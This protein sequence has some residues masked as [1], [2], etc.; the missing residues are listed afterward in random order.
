MDKSMKLKYSPLYLAISVALSGCLNSSDSTVSTGVFVDNLVSGMAYETTTQS[1]FTNTKGEFKYAEGETVTFKVGGTTLGTTTG[2]GVISPIDLDSNASKTNLTAK[3][4]NIAQLL[5]TLDSDLDPNNGIDI[6]ESTRTALVNTSVNLAAADF[7]SELNTRLPEAQRP[8]TTKIT[9]DIAKEHLQ[10][11]LAQYNMATKE[12]VTT[13]TNVSEVTRYA[14]DTTAVDLEYKGS[15]VNNFASQNGKLKLGVGSGLGLLEEAS[16]TIKLVTI[17]DRGPNLDAPEAGITGNTDGYAYT[18]S[19]IFPLP[20]YAP[21]FAIMTVTD[22]Q[23]TLDAS[24]V[25]ELKNQ[26][27]E[28]ISGR[29]LLPGTTGA[30][31]EVAIAENLKQLTGDVN[32]LD[33][34]GIVKDAQG[35]YWICDEYGPFIIKLDSTG[36]ELARYEAGKVSGA[37]TGLGLPAIVKQRRPNRGMEGVALSPEGMVYGL[38]QSPLYTIE[39]GKTSQYKKGAFLRLVQLDPVT[40]ETKVF[41]VPTKAKTLTSVGVA[42][43]DVKAG[44]L[45]A[46]GNGK[47]LMIEQGKDLS[48]KLFND[49]TLLD[50]TGATDL[51]SKDAAYVANMTNPTAS[52]VEQL[53][54]YDPKLTDAATAIDTKAAA[55]DALFTSN[56]ITPVVKTQLFNLRD[57]GWLAEKAE[58]LTVLADKQTIFVMNDNDFGVG[59]K[60]TGGC[61]AKE[62]D[63]TAYGVDV[64][65]G[66]FTL[67]DTSCIAKDTFVNTV[68]NKPEERQTRLWKIKLANAIQ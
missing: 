36:K 35:N 48:G 62:G 30:T 43:K 5:Q 16:G 37:A 39:N 20:N 41:A 27:G 51:T 4:T 1:G 66:E 67:S 60:L 53:V 59:F 34:E 44:D 64:A 13:V 26:A 8:T 25:K 11:T 15:F 29:P 7:T 54:N 47:F 49:V 6:S 52:S 68:Q 23:A 24:T 9:R 12:T 3:V 46:L 31:G 2:K 65:K 18:A 63:I 14:V 61:S 22:T 17:T 45:V 58:G 28:V 33:P 32:G 42:P 21:R 56:A 19:K 38:V 10:T 50:I 57:I 55:R 40:G